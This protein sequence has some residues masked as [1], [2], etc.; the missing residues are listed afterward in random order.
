MTDEIPELTT[1]YGSSY[2]I[3]ATEVSPS[4]THAES[5]CRSNVE[6]PFEVIS[7]QSCTGT[8]L[9]SSLADRANCVRVQI[10]VIGVQEELDD[11]VSGEDDE[12]NLDSDSECD[13]ID[14]GSEE[15]TEGYI[16]DEEGG[17][18]PDEASLDSDANAVFRD[19]VLH[20]HGSI[21]RVC[22]LHPATHAAQ[23]AKVS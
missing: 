16:T 19:T 18:E 2:S 20:V 1:A 21:R 22:H 6:R 7:L 13:D 10:F 11:Y 3:P 9:T 8:G 23:E 12:D 4:E 5:H 14:V 15:D 17:D